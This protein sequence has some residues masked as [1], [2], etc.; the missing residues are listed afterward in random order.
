MPLEYLHDHKEFSALLRIVGEEQRIDPYLV[1]KDYWIMHSLYGLQQMDLKFELKGGTSLSKG[2]GIT[3]RFSEDID[4]RIEPPETLSVNT[5]P[6][7]NRSNQVEGR[8]KY[9]DWLAEH[10]RIHGISEIK[11]DTV[12][13]DE[14]YYR[15]GGIRLH[16]PVQS[17]VLSG[18]KDGLLLEV[19]FDDISPNI[20]RTITSWAYEFAKE[21]EYALFR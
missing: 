14:R 5:N 21:H 2:F 16:Y 20:P 7:S 10:I 19:G 9:Y 1:E 11:R 15:S 8:K 12:F 4:I 3:D 6:K 17:G 18:I 13:D